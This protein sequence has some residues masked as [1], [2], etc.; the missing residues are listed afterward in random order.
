MVCPVTCKQSHEFSGFGWT[1]VGLGRVRLLLILWSAAPLAGERQ[2]L[3]AFRQQQQQQPMEHHQKGALHHALDPGS[4]ARAHQGMR[5]RGARRRARASA[6]D[7]AAQE[8]RLVVCIAA[9]RKRASAG[10]QSE[11]STLIVVNGR[12][13]HVV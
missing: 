8:G 3:A 10:R 9:F 7:L 12:A 5:S 2:L 1:R 4:G 6:G 11:P 13:N